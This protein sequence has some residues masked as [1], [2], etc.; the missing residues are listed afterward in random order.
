MDGGRALAKE[1][2]PA[3][4]ENV[5]KGTFEPIEAAG[6]YVL[7]KPEDKDV[8]FYKAESGTIAAGKAY[9]ELD[10]D[11]KAFF[12][13]FNGE[14]TG[15][16]DLKDIKNSQDIIFNIAGQRLNKAQ[17]GINIVNGKKILF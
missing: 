11:I 2:A 12:F 17:K 14:A 15:I 13:D 5:L 8:C 16:N 9:L 1:L 10:S 3:L 7:A 4:E 6:K